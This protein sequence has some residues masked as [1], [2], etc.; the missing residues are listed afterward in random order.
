MRKD[1]FMKAKSQLLAVIACPQRYIV[2][3]HLNC[4]IQIFWRD[5]DGDVHWDYLRYITGSP[6]APIG[7]RVD[8]F[9][10]E[11]RRLEQ[12]WAGK[13]TL[14]KGCEWINQRETHRDLITTVKEEWSEHEFDTSKCL[15][16]FD[17]VFPVDPYHGLRHGIKNVADELDRWHRSHSKY[18]P[19]YGR[20]TEEEYQRLVRPIIAALPVLPVTYQC[21]RRHRLPF[22][23]RMRTAALTLSRYLDDRIYTSQWTRALTYLGVLPVNAAAAQTGIVKSIR[24][25]V[26]AGVASTAAGR[27]WFKKLNA[28]SL[29]G[30]WARREETAR[31]QT[32][33]E[34]AFA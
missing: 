26:R 16:R 21:L 25:A 34:E 3:K 2:K 6:F 24:R 31:N 30:S 9:G 12:Y 5:A 20:I 23:E 33:K 4:S 10:D 17:A 19:H 15:V 14:V 8:N 28:L 18:D 1:E 29:L 7:F 22:A 13:A 32:N 11:S 27:K